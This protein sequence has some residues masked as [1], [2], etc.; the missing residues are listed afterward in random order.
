MDSL[1]GVAPNAPAP[2]GGDSGLPSQSSID[3]WLRTVIVGDLNA[4]E[5]QDDKG[6]C[7]APKLA[8]LNGGSN[9]ANDLLILASDTQPR[10]YPTPINPFEVFIPGSPANEAWTRDVERLIQA[11]RDALRGQPGEDGR[12]GAQEMARPAPP[13]TATQPPATAPQTDSAGRVIS[14]RATMPPPGDCTPGQHRQL[15]D[16]VDTICKPSPPRCVPEMTRSELETNYQRNFSCAQAR[17]RLNSQCFAG[18]NLGHREQALDKWNAAAR[19]RSYIG[20]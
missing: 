8:S 9:G 5:T 19:C 16:D 11:G 12:D 20:S 1:D 13:G 4:G 18:G 14:P 7:V 15:Q 3:E 6:W 2:A 17:D 10:G